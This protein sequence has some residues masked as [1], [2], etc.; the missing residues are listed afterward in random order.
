VVFASLWLGGRQL[1]V[2][3][4][5]GCYTAISLFISHNDAKGTKK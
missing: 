4:G 1:G 3:A 5:M 2:A